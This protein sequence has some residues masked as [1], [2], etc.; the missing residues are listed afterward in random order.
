MTLII[1][2]TNIDFMWGSDEVKWVNKQIIKLVVFCGTIPLNILYYRG[3][4][5]LG[6]CLFL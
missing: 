6:L 4:A 5:T 2:R 1:V 3:R